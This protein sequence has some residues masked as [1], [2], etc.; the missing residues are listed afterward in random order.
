LGRSVDFCSRPGARKVHALVK[1][2]HRSREF[3]EFLKLLDVAYPAQTAIK[4]IVGLDLVDGI[5]SISIAFA[6][7]GPACFRSIR[8]GRPMERSTLPK[9]VVWSIQGAV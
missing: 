5:R 8:I 4:V 3:I 1:D 6:S 9:S 7:D 2:R